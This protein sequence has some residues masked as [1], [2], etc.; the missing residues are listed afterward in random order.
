[1]AVVDLGE[2]LLY[3]RVA[4]LAASRSSRTSSSSTTGSFVSFLNADALMAALNWA[5]LR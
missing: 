3:R 2:F 4:Q 5:A 1:M